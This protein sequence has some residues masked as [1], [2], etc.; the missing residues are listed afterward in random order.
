MITQNNFKTVICLVITNLIVFGKNIQSPWL[1]FFE[2]QEKYLPMYRTFSRFFIRF[3][4][5]LRKIRLIQKK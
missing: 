2:I 4:Q 1:F 5:F 3:S